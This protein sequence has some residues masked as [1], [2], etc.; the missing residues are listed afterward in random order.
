M[1]TSAERLD[2]LQKAA[3]HL[4]AA[5]C[6]K[7]AA[8]VAAWATE[9]KQDLAAHL[10]EVSV[11]LKEAA[12]ELE[13]E[14]TAAGTSETA[15]ACK[16]AACA[17]PSTAAPLAAAPQHRDAT[18]LTMVDVL[19]VEVNLTSMREL[20]LNFP[21]RGFRRSS[22][23]LHGERLCGCAGSHSRH[24]GDAAKERCGADHRSAPRQLATKHLPKQPLL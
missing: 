1:V 4:A 10:R 19:A 21:E 15:T 14:L 7:E 18:Q 20:G 6:E 9:V 8:C 12:S 23:I 22:G 2:H 3:E 5:G 11:E 24:D 13:E 16:S 17:C